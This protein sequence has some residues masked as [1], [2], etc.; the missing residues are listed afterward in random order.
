MNQFFSPQVTLIIGIILSFVLP[1]DSKIKQSAKRWSSTILQLSVVLL[2]ANLNLNAVISLGLKGILLT[3]T[4]ILIVFFSGYLLNKLFKIETN[5][6]TLLTSGSAICGGSAIGAIAPILQASPLSVATSMGVIFILNAIA[7]Y[8]FPWLGTWL[9]LT[10]EQFGLW[11]ALAIHDTS[12]VVAAAGLYGKEALTTATTIKLTRALWIIPL[13]LYFSVQMKSKKQSLNKIKLPWF[14]FA[15]IMMSI[16]FSLFDPS[17]NQIKY[18]LAQT[19]KLG[20][21]LT[22]L[23]IGIGLELKKLKEIGIKSLAYALLLWI[24]ISIT[25]L[26]I[27]IH[28]L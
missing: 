18:Y 8:L 4:V 9:Q 26:L 21:A 25:T 24:I 15:F 13:S 6:W 2:G 17:L 27:I 16:I 5:L 10:Q 1:S 7:I 3:L 20:F 12:S 19:S 11:S 22:L 14:I 28:L 23:L